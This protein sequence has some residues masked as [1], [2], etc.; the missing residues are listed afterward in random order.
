MPLTRRSLLKWGATTVGAAGLGSAGIAFA[1]TGPGDAP[2]RIVDEAVAQGAAPGIQLAVWQHGTPLV[3]YAA[4]KA[5]LETGT[6]AGT[7]SIFRI[8]SLTKQFVAAL[9]AVLAEQR[10]LDLDA[11]ASR[12]LPSFAGKPAF[13]VRELIHHT[14]GLHSDE[15][16]EALAGPVTQLRL[17]EA[18]AAQATLFDF[19]PGT[20]WQYSN[21][22]YH[23]LGAIIEQVAGQPL[24][25]VGR[26]L[27]FDR[28]GMTRTAFDHSGDIVPGR[29]AGYAFG[30]G[31]P[32]NLEH[33]P[34]IDVV[35]A[36]GAGA[37]RG[38]ADDL[39]RWHAALLDGRLVN[40]AGLR[41][42]LAPGRLRDGRLAS[43]HRAREDDAAMGATE[44]GFGLLLDRATRD[45]SLIVQHNGF[46][47][48]YSAY[49]AT[50]VPSRL[51]VAC[52][53]NADPNPGL[54]FRALR[55]A[56]FAEV[57]APSR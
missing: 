36:G 37:M 56:V 38:T 9:A 39:C 28:L 26:T 44:Y 11:Q 2:R 23:V 35:Q 31:D 18:I 40:A 47:A 16:G 19:P 48:G 41:A 32:P 57:L 12:F 20:A 54:P 42:M 17:A 14:A 52:L 8:G 51:T 30:E 29:V 50:H 27:L 45:G 6:V 43:A 13:T 4:G 34:C 22:N 24:A 5:N 1:A 53:C 46:I 3:A 7:N 15:A 55:R 49:L 10:K 21:A 25:E 33:A